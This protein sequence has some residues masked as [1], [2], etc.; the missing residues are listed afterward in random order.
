MFPYR[1]GI[2]TF[3][4][5][6]AG[7]ILLAPLWGSHIWELREQILARAD[8]QQSMGLS[9]SPSIE[10]FQNL[11]WSQ[12]F[13]VGSLLGFLFLA[14]PLAMVMALIESLAL[15]VR[16]I[17][18]RWGIKLVGQLWFFTPLGETLSAFTSSMVWTI[19]AWV[20]LFGLTLG[21]SKIVE[22][23]RRHLPKLRMKV[24]LLVCFAL[25]LSVSHWISHPIWHM[26]FYSKQY[27]NIDAM[28]L[29]RDW[30]LLDENGDN[31]VND[32]YYNHTV[33]PMEK[34]RITHFQP[35][36]IGVMDVDSSWNRHLLTFSTDKKGWRGQRT[37]LIP[38]MTDHEWDLWLGKGLLDIVA[39]DSK[40]LTELADRA[41]KCPEG[42]V[43]FLGPL[44]TAKINGLVQ[45]SKISEFYG[46]VYERW[47]Y[48]LKHTPVVDRKDQIQDHG[49]DLLQSQVMNRHK[50]ALGGLLSSPV[51]LT[52]TLALMMLSFL[53]FLIQITLCLVQ[54]NRL[55]LWAIIVLSSPFWLSGLM[56]NS[57]FWKDQVNDTQNST[58][59]KLLRYHR[60]FVKID[61]QLTHEVLNQTLNQDRRLAMWQVACLGAAYHA[62]KDR[63]IRSKIT[64]WM[65]VALKSY[66]DYPFNMRYKLIEA[67]SAMPELLDLLDQVCREEKHPYVRYYAEG[68]GLGV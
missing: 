62:T 32:W 6:W 15:S 53:W 47:G 42:S 20:S 22:M 12:V 3:L 11:S 30:F 57:S 9:I 68:Y 56:Q 33:F 18:W 23:V 43:I 4:L 28:T 51:L 14:L 54:K 46:G 59:R 13:G 49:F 26:V 7:L 36:L 52:S 10:L 2:L 29:V 35:M 63:S 67:A 37:H 19:F 40:H 34:E 50:R 64:E 38:L 16:S 25:S 66:P 17:K 55:I 24:L 41:K 61:H 39:V 60:S 8:F 65:K 31:W 44:K 27:E 1:L 58:E 21:I 45:I 5:W 48:R